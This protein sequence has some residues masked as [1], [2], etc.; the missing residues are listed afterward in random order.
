MQTVNNNFFHFGR[1]GNLFIVGFAMHF[2]AL[3]N[4]LKVSYKEHN[5]FIKLGIDWFSGQ[6]T[7]D[8]TVKL[9]DS[10]F[11]QMITGK[12]TK[13]NI[14]IIND[15]WCQTKEFAQ[16]LMKY[17]NEEPQKNK[18]IQNNIFNYN[19]NKNE[20]LYVHVRLGDVAN[21]YA[22]PFTYYDKALSNIKFKKGYISS[23]SINN[24]LCK[25]LIEKYDLKVINLDEIETI[26]F[27]STCKYIV[28]SSG[29]YSWMIGLLAFYSQIY[30]PKIY[31]VW[32][33]D[34]FVYPQWSEIEYDNK[35]N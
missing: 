22:H 15:M 4:N 16:Y 34:I 31:K 12:E 17:M 28:L 18:I 23:D 14:S 8:C 7:Y 27:A 11:F 13:V 35:N 33:G 32:H 6:N 24:P 19:Y 29:T 30:Y 3:K 26:M 5:K 2:I 21:S 25:K 10:N 1:L 9:T 20:D